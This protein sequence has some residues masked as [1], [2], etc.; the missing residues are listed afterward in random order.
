M[1]DQDELLIILMVSIVSSAR[2]SI[3]SSETQ[4]NCFSGHILYDL[5]PRKV[6][7]CFIS[8]LFSLF[9]FLSKG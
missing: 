3:N 5:V 2:H 1:N 6:F 7:D 9:Q 8:E 4:V